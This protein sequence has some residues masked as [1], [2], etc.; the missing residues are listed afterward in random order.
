[1]QLPSK[2]DIRRFTAKVHKTSGCWL[3][4]ACTDTKGY[5]LFGFAGHLIK[6]H[7]FS[8]FLH[9]GPVP[10]RH[11]VRQ[12]CGNRHCVRPKHLYT[13]EEHRRGNYF[14]LDKET[15]NFLDGLLLGDGCYAS[16][17]LSAVFNYKIP[18][19]QRNS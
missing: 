1:M 17:K 4:T 13:S 5:G 12:T 8:W 2:Y 6:A 7:R 16:N 3:W 10:A 11:K 14:T 18:V 15:K 19:Q 9:K